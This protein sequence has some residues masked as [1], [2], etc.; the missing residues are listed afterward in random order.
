MASIKKTQKKKI[1]SEEPPITNLEDF[2]KR[3]ERNIENDG[4]HDMFCYRGVGDANYPLIPGLYRPLNKALKIDGILKKESEVFMKFIHL[5][6]PLLP[7]GLDFGPPDNYDFWGSLFFMQHWGFPTR[8]LDWT[9]NP[10]VALFFA[11]SQAKNKIDKLKSKDNKTDEEEIIDA[12]VWVINT[13]KW[14]RHFLGLEDVG[15]LSVGNSWLDKYVIK[16]P[17]ANNYKTELENM[18]PFPL[19]MY[20]IH[21]NARI[22]VQKGMFLIFGQDISPMEVQ[23]RKANN[24]KELLDKIVIK[25]EYIEGLFKTLYSMGFTDSFVYPDLQGLANEIRRDTGY[26][27][28][29]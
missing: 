15:I 29:G 18:N 9:R 5:G 12:A 4:E 25:N 7:M 13:V 6:K 26:R 27:V 1:D 19:A 20:G 11:L 23:I 10:Y 22:S 14:N 24:Q 2:T 16:H 28:G 17:S 8:L 3:I 21:N